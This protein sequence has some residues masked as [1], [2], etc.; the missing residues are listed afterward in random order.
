MFAICVIGEFRFLICHEC[1]QHHYCN[2]VFLE[3]LESC[4]NVLLQ[5]QSWLRRERLISAERWLP[6]RGGLSQPIARADG[7]NDD[8]GDD[9][10]DEDVDDDNEVDIVTNEALDRVVLWEDVQGL[11]VREVNPSKASRIRLFLITLQ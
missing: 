7:D 1:Q 10:V 3:S 5:A 8:E 6:A 4:A 11:Q 9:D 2:F